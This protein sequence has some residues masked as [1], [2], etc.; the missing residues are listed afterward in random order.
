MKYFLVLALTSIQL[1]SYAQA[2]V[3]RID[4]IIAVAESLE[5]DGA[6]DKANSNYE[7][8]LLGLEENNSNYGDLLLKVFNYYLVKNNSE[9][10]YTYF[11]KIITS[12]INDRD[13]EA[14]RINEPFK[15]YRYRATK[16][17]AD[18]YH[19]HGDQSKSLEYIDLLE[20]SIPYETTLLSN[21][22][23]E[24]IDLA[25]SRSKIYN[26]LEKKDSAF[27]FLFKRALEYDYVD[28]FP[29]FTSNNNCAEE[30]VLSETIFS[31][32]SSGVAFQGFKNNLDSAINSIEIKKE[33]T[34]SKIKLEFQNMTYIIPVYSIK[35]TKEDYMVY[36]RKSPLYIA[37]TEKLNLVKRR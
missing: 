8:L 34:S 35:E 10:A 21:Y 23:A 37:L 32:Y 30:K 4:S 11:E 20:F 24:K 3:R 26:E 13:V 36:L 22:K 31:Y 12:N 7:S 18:F 25:T 2:S 1:A 5:N 16:L 27:Y 28:Q 9:K 29:N 15:N 19:R 33:E 17:M 14:K 6:I